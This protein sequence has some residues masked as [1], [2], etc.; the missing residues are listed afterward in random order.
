MKKIIALYFCLMLLLTGCHSEKETLFFHQSTENITLIEFVDNKND[1]V[2]C[3]ISDD[4]TIISIVNDLSVIPCNRHFNDPSGEYG[5]Y[6]I[7]LHYNDGSIEI[8][9]LYALGYVSAEGEDVDMWHYLE[10][11]SFRALFLKYAN[12]TIIR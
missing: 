10:L 1:H 8:V 5:N 11:D 9:G 7:R 2:M 4:P 3:A 6:L 12:E